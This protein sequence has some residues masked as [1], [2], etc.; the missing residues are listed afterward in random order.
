MT[1]IPHPPS[2][3]HRRPLR[4]R[5]EPLVELE[6]G[7]AGLFRSIDGA[8]W[9]HHPA[10][11]A[12][13]AL[14]GRSRRLAA[15]ASDGDFLRRYDEVMARMAHETLERRHLVRPGPPGVNGRPVAYFCAEFGLHNS[16]PIYCGGLGVLAGDHCKA[17]SDLGVPMVGVG[18]LLHEGLLRPAAAARRMAGGQRRG[19][20][21]QPHPARAGSGR[22]QEG[23]LATV[24]TSGRPVHVRAWKM[25][26]GRVP[27]YLLD[28]NLEINHPDDRGLMN[29]LYAGGPD[30]RLRQE[31]ILGVGGVRV[32][33]AMGDRARRLARQRGARGLHA[34]GAPARVRGAGHELRRRGAA[35][36]AAAASSRPTRRC[37]PVTTRSRSS[38]SRA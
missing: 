10:Q 1:T 28:T 5:H 7:G 9:H 12:G 36:C 31:W 35:R 34:G 14:P 27:I 17:S 3:P 25:M 33:R 13:A 4:T 32:L 23:Y 15:C 11:S 24:E 30:L 6:P 26:V 37:R 16:V 18:P 8:L 22:K 19:V 2:R 21:H 38:S 20:R 29:K